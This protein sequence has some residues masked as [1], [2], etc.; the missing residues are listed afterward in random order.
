MTLVWEQTDC[1]LHFIKTYSDSDTGFGL[2]KVTM[3]KS[4]DHVNML[5][6]HEAFRDG[7]RTLVPTDWTGLFWEY[8]EMDSILWNFKKS[9]GDSGKWM[10][11]LR[12]L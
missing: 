10:F 4:L 6:L 2:F 12:L 9:W 8:E 11:L 7:Q 1:F 5:R 3:L